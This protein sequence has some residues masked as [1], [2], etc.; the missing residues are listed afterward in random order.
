ME[1]N[2]FNKRDTEHYDY[3]Q[4]CKFQ[5]NFTE[6]QFEKYI[7]N[8][9]DFNTEK[10]VL[11]IHIPFCKG[12]CIFC[13][14]YKEKV[15]F[16]SDM[17]KYCQSLIKEIR[18]YGSVLPLKLKYISAIHF[19]GGTPTVLSINLI[20]TI[21]D[22]IKENFELSTNCLISME[23]SIKDFSNLEYTDQLSCTPINRVS[24]GIQSF[25]ED[26]RNKYGLCD[27]EKV[28]AAVSNIVNAGIEDFNADLM[29]NFPEQN[30]ED[31]ISDIN[32]AFDLGINCVDLYSLNV[33]PNT[34]MHN[35]LVK[36][37]TFNKYQ[38]TN[39]H[40]QY[41]KVYDYIR[42]S[43]DIFTVM[44]NTFSKKTETPNDF[45]ST[46]LGGNKNNSGSIIGIGA[47]ARG[48]VDGFA[49]K[50]HIETKDYI[51]SVDENRNGRALENELT[52]DEI[53]NRTL[54]MFP[55]FTYMN[56]KDA[57]ISNENSEIIYHLMEN[58]IIRE[59]KEKY[60]IDVDK[61]YW[62][63]NISG[64]FYSTKQKKK[65]TKSLLLNMK[66]RL[67]MYNQDKMQIQNKKG[68]CKN[69]N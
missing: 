4:L 30:S 62:A 67:N 2:F 35:F 9:V 63:G 6:S 44:S 21:I 7:S 10:T 61:C 47:S 26:L 19:G 43:A 33:F 17:D 11:Y 29:Y 8:K 27:I 23:G 41:T 5:D 68:W 3:P 22:A 32:K 57:I 58:N 24:F 55:N 37:Q 48:Y 40:M 18:Y 16:E 34:S 53:H 69:E 15:H 28:Y 36:N 64:M 42:N 39:N 65:M 54:V 38:D 59:D 20:N 31:V 49:Y 12:F 66:N 51:S 25:S 14:Y 60:F 56:K 1:K 52:L 13:N 50:N 45:I 46:H